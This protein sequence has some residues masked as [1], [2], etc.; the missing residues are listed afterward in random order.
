[1]DPDTPASTPRISAADR[2]DSGMHVSF[3][4]GEEGFYSQE[5]LYSMLDR[6]VADGR[7]AE[8]ESMLS[9]QDKER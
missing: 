9:G 5:L 4:N 2:F 6:T 7:P 1:M 8:P 3:E